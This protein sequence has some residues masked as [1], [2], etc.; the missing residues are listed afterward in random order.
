MCCQKKAIVKKI[1]V[2]KEQPKKSVK[3]KKASN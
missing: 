2:K 3:I 1:L